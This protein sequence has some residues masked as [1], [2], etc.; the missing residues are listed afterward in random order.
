MSTIDICHELIE[1]HNHNA[2]DLL[3][4]LV[5][6]LPHAVLVEHLEYISD[7]EDWTYKVDSSGRIYDS[8]KFVDG[9]GKRLDDE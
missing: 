6:S 7:I 1:D 2:K 8:E 3:F 5:R 4:S 9:S